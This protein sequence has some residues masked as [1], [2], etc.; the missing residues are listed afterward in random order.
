MNTLYHSRRK[1]PKSF[2][3]SRATAPTAIARILHLGP[4]LP[5]LP[6]LVTCPNPE[7]GRHGDDGK[8]HRRRQRHIQ[9]YHCPTHVGGEDTRSSPS[10]HHRKSIASSLRQQPALRQRALQIW[11]VLSRWLPQQ[12]NIGGAQSGGQTAEFVD[13]VQTP[14]RRS[15]GTFF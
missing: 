3:R 7:L 2:G 13:G 12:G 4:A 6:T 5:P 9:P 10:S 15:P 11:S 14:G 1:A 8:T